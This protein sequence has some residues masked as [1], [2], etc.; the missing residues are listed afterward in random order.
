MSVAALLVRCSDEPAPTDELPITIPEQVSV[1]SLL[2]RE[3]R[4]PHVADPPLQPRGHGRPLVEPV[5]PAG[6]SLWRIVVTVGAL[7]AVGATFGAPLLD[8]TS[9]APQRAT[10]PGAGRAVAGPA[11]SA[12]GTVPAPGPALTA[13]TADVDAADPG[14]AR[15]AVV[16]PFIVTGDDIVGDALP[17]VEVVALPSGGDGAGSPPPDLPPVAGGPPDPGA[18]ER[19][20]PA[21][22]DPGPGRV[23]AGPGTA[24]AELP[25]PAEATEG[26]EPGIGT[27]PAEV[28]P[29]DPA[30][31]DT[32]VA[33]PDEGSS[34][35]DPTAPGDAPPEVPDPVVPDPVVTDP[36]VPDPVVPDPEVTDPPTDV[37]DPDP[38]PDVALPGSPEA[39]ADPPVEAPAGETGETVDATLGAAGGLLGGV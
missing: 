17:P 1:A 27:P 20:A 22:V 19:V 5:E 21:P 29:P 25:A 3:G 32:G 15:T 10:D 9:H 31:P 14:P 35:V 4:G 6:R 37:D 24:R 7:L 30:V 28:V 13:G 26:G 38:P 11:P 23:V 18:P 33:P 2:R 39:P 8:E 12:D 36:V 16:E 34:G